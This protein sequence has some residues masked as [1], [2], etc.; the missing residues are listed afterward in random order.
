MLVMFRC[1]WLIVCVSKTFTVCGDFFF[2]FSAHW[3]LNW[4][5]WCLQVLYEEGKDDYGDENWVQ[6]VYHIESAAQEF[7]EEQKRCLANCDAP[8]DPVPYAEL[9]RKII[10]TVSLHDRSKLVS[11]T[12]AILL[13][14]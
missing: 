7:Y 5:Q 11:G 14:P 1:I 13:F 10:G 8:F 2:S 6:A 12:L 4:C 9:Y 3:W